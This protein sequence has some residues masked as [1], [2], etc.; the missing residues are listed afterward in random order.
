MRLHLLAAVLT[1]NSTECHLICFFLPGRQKMCLIG[2]SF[3]KLSVLRLCP[4]IFFAVSVTGWTEFNANQFYFPEF[5][6]IN[7]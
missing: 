3:W 2:K 6:I 5:A 4:V 7:L 1:D